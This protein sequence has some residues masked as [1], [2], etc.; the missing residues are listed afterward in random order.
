ME[1]LIKDL[2]VLEFAGTGTLPNIGHVK[3]LL[4]EVKYGLT[5]KETAIE[6]IERHIPVVEEILAAE[7]S[8]TNREGRNLI[9]KSLELLK[10]L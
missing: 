10:S 8:Y 7:E 3:N 1:E 5:T 4:A 2:T 9:F 6:E